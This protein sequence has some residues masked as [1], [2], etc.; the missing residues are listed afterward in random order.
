M[1][2]DISF[3]GFGNQGVVTPP[4][5][6]SV[7]DIAVQ[8]DGR[9]VVVG[10]TATNHQLAVYRYLS[11][12]QLDTSFDGDGKALVPNM[13]GAEAVALYSDGRIVVGGTRWNG[14]GNGHDFQLARL[15][16]SGA[17]D[18]SFD[19]DG[20]AEDFDPELI[21]LD[22]ILVQ[23]DGKIV[24]CGYAEVGGDEDFGVTRY[25]ENGARDNS[26]GGDGKVT[27]GFGGNDRCHDLALQN[28]GKLLVVGMMAGSD[29]DFAV[30]R[31]E[32][33]G[34]LSA[35]ASSG[36]AVEFRSATDKG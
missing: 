25:N 9:L 13:F 23:P 5:L 2:L 3:A 20:W 34:T 15:T 33:N 18:P 27:I 14:S 26:F 35:T 17:L 36:L 29:D 32:S 10:P 19:G 12:G 4:E 8:P 7:N 24:A 21:W 30:A 6:A 1:K 16:P 31:L 22:A 11:N 28:D